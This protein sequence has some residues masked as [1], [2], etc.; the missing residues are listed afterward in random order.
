MEFAENTY[1]ENFN[2]FKPQCKNC[3]GLCC[4]ALYFSKTDGFP[5]DKPAGSPCANLNSDYRCKIHN[6]LGRL[7]MKGCMAY[8][9]FGAGQQ[10]SQVTYTGQS[11]REQPSA[12]ATMF[13]VFVIVRQLN[14]MC[15][16]L[17]EALSY[18]PEVFFREKLLNALHETE[19]LTD[20]APDALL[21]LDIALHREKIGALLKRASE[22][23]RD[24]L[25]KSMNMEKERTRTPHGDSLL[26]KDLRKKEL[27]CADLRGAFLI[28][29]NLEGCNLT[30][31]DFLGAD[32]RDTNIKGADLS[33]SLFLSQPQINAAK[34]DSNTKLP[35]VLFRPANWD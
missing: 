20:S 8:E 14:E 15:W 9:C 26:G 35:T 27:R 29:A 21:E 25:R 23:I 4:I 10:V 33:K 5:A 16:Y 12:A 2:R 30:G 18:E 22:Q 11:W 13:D 17:T 32:F 28:A 6:Q 31:T 1:L 24:V 19:G 3:F 7:G 34:G